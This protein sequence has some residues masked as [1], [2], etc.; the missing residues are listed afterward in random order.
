LISISSSTCRRTN[1]SVV[2]VLASEQD[3]PDTV[4]FR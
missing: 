2:S 3:E 4:T 1:H